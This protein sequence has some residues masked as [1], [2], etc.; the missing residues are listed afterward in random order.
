[1]PGW[2]PMV[3]AASVI[4]EMRS[5]SDSTSHHHLQQL[6]DWTGW[7]NALTSQVTGLHT[8]GLLLMG[9]Y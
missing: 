5:S 8:I 2:C 7:A 3:A 1:M 6:L 9:P 4:R